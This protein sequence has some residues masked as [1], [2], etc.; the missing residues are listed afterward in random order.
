MSRPRAAGVAM[1]GMIA[2]LS[3]ARVDPGAQP[4][5]HGRE[6]TQPLASSIPA[7]PIHSVALPTRAEAPRAEAPPRGVEAEPVEDPVAIELKRARMLSITPLGRVG[8]F[9]AALA[10]PPPKSQAQV[11]LTLDVTTSPATHRRSLAFYRLA[12]AL[13][14]HSVPAVAI[15]RIT[16]GELTDLLE[17]NRELLAVMRGLIV[18]QNDGTVDALL[19][20]PSPGEPEAAWQRP[21]A[22]E[23]AVNS[24]YDVDHWMRW[25]ASPVPFPGESPPLL[26]DFVELL[27]L[28][29]LSAN[30]L[31]RTILVDDVAQRLILADNTTAFPPRAEADALVRLLERLRQVARYPRTLR[32]E[33]LKFDRRRMEA[34]FMPGQFESWILTPRNLM[35]L[36]ERRATLLSLLDARIT[37]RGAEAVLS[38]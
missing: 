16:A 21:L 25:A 38:L 19:A 18:L 8:V 4:G 28:D 35:D 33:L 32:D 31:R 15:R 3:C 36:E 6:Q 1:L 12:R 17:V 20:A 5:Q 23:I 29:Y 34:L 14:M 26:R 27:V 30:V 13:G 2:A 11:E 24:S 9:A 22:R 7:A 10:V 37:E